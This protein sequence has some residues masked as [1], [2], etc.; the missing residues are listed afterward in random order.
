MKRVIGGKRYDTEK[1]ESIGTWW[2]GY[3][4]NDFNFCREELFLTKNGCYFL[5]GEGGAMSRYAAGH[6]NSVGGGESIVPLSLDEAFEWAQNHLAPE[7]FEDRF[8]DMIE[9]A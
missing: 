6:G 4:Q 2:N 5:H 7:E 8:T 1:A 9:D 3:G